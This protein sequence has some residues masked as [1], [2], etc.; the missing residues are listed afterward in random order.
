M[1][2]SLTSL[3]RQLF[4]PQVEVHNQQYIDPPV[5]TLW[6]Q[7]I[8]STP[9]DEPVRFPVGHRKRKL[10]K[11][12]EA[13]CTLRSMAGEAG[14]K[15]EVSHYYSP[16][17]FEVIAD[18]IGTFNPMRCGRPVSVA[19]KLLSAVPSTLGGKGYDLKQAGLMYFTPH[20]AGVRRSR[21]RT[22]SN[23]IKLLEHWAEKFPDFQ[24]FCSAY[25]TEKSRKEILMDCI[26]FHLGILPPNFVTALEKNNEKVRKL[27][28]Q[29]AEK[30]RQDMAA[31]QQA[32]QQHNN[33]MQANMY[34]A[35]G[36]SLS[37][38]S[39]LAQNKLLGQYQ[40]IKE[41]QNLLT[42][43]EEARRTMEM[44]KYQMLMDEQRKAS[45]ALLR[46]SNLLLTPVWK[47][48]I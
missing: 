31:K 35:L 23:G 19:M 46:K 2:T 22:T 36:G 13:L 4:E 37:Q 38:Q 20:I 14:S 25:V 47:D 32:M 43:A 15:E 17:P 41:Q 16:I 10:T 30:V 24:P 34:G 40:M 18:T 28:E 39:M 3:Y 48:V 6:P 11:F 5:Q 42:A 44:Q 21:N 27:N 9:V 29:V 26:D 12:E 7:A 33:H 45:E 1:A 8:G